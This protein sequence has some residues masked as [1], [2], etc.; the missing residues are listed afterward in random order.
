VID[1]RILREDP[2]RVR[3]GQLKRGESQGLVD[4]I[5]SADERRRSAIA[6]YEQLRAEQKRLGK[7]IPQ[8]KGEERKSL[9]AKT[10]DLAGQVK[11]AE[12]AQ[13]E[14]EAEFTRSIM[15]SWAGCSGQSTYSAVQ[16][17]AAPASTT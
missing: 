13:T 3:A 6:E 12:T 8:A 1:L 16:R 9:L 14:A 5:L 15:W 10:G 7:Q 17:P 4:E 2:D 11:K